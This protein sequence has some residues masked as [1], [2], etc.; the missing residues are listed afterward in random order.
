MYYSRFQHFIDFRTADDYF[1]DKDDRDL[2]DADIKMM[3][4]RASSEALL[5]SNEKY[6]DEDEFLSWIIGMFDTFDSSYSYYSEESKPHSTGSN[7]HS[8][9]NSLSDLSYIMYHLT[10]Y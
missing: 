8:V 10:F 1:L 9:Q 4:F 5:S 3:N 2:E 7:T 6:P